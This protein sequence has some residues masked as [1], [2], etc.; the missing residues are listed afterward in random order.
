[1]MTETGSAPC[2]NPR[3]TRFTEAFGEAGAALVR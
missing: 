2:A 1:M 3:T